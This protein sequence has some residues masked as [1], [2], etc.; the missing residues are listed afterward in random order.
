MFPIILRGGDLLIIHTTTKGETSMNKLYSSWA[1]HF[2]KHGPRVLLVAGFLVATLVFSA[3][4]FAPSA[5]A[6]SA[7][8]TAHSLSTTPLAI[9]PDYSCPSRSICFFQHDNYTGAHFACATNVCRGA[10][11][12]TTVGGVHAGSVNDNS[13]SVFLLLDAQGGIEICSPPGR[14]DLNHGYGYFDV[15]YGVTSCADAYTPPPLP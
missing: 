12:S 4:S 6:A 14:Y 8:T 9:S 3:F 7:S 5:Y 11:Y 2:P 15:L 10:W 1:T 13:N